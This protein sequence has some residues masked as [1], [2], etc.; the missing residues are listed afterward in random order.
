MKRTRIF[1]AMFVM[2]IALIAVGCK[3]KE[4]K[5]DQEQE[6]RME[7]HSFEE[8]LLSYPSDFEPF[9]SKVLNNVSVKEKLSLGMLK[10]E[11]GM[12]ITYEKELPSRIEVFSL[13]EGKLPYD[14]YCLYKNKRT[15]LMDGSMIIVHGKAS[16]KSF[17]LEPFKK[18]WKK[19][20]LQPILR[21]YS[22]TVYIPMGDYHVPALESYEEF[23]DVWDPD[24]DIVFYIGEP[25][26]DFIAW[27]GNKPYLMKK[28]GK[29]WNERK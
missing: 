6:K 16:V 26:P 13:N 24:N 21:K 9:L 1:L 22:L 28:S 8:N 4:G 10:L 5:L 27:E 29:F 15:F 20:E 18:E 2:A 3:N 19:D 7:Q 17:T 23:M 25:R 11:K 12:E 14:V